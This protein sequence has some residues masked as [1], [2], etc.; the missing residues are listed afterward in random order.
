MD[1][2]LQKLNQSI[3]DY[4]QMQEKQ[5]QAFETELMPDIETF[6]FER[7][8]V[9]ADLKNDLDHFLN[10]LHDAG[11]VQ[12]GLFYQNKIKTIME[13][14]MILKD[15]I[16]RHKNLLQQHMGNTRNSRTAVKGYAGSVKTQNVKTVC[17]KG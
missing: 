3:Q 16:S 2:H 12:S 6:N 7:A 9:F 10:F 11:Q 8:F 17:L 13:T 1:Q 5:I 14:D 4:Q 15:K